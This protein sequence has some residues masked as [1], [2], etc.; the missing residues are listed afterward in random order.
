MSHIRGNI[1]EDRTSPAGHNVYLKKLPNGYHARQCREC[2]NARQRRY[3]KRKA[4][5]K[6]VKTL[7]RIQ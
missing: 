5:E 6:N 3:N 1:P 2:G 7:P 4:E